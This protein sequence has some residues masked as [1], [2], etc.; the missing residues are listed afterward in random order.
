[1]ADN[2]PLNF[3]WL[4]DKGEGNGI[5]LLPFSLLLLANGWRVA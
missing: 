1:M 2:D 5:S 4:I 3:N